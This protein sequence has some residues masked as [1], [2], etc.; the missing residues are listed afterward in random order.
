MNIIHIAGTK[1]KGSTCAFV[2]SL[3]QSHQ[4]RTGFPKKIG[5]YTSPHLIEY[6][7]RIRINSV[8]LPEET[9]GK[10]C[11]DIWNCLDSRPQSN[12]PR[13]L[14]FLALLSYHTFLK[15]GV[16]AAIY[17]THHGGEYDVTNIVEK[18][19]VTALTSIGLDHIG[20]LGPSIENIAWHKAGIFKKDVYAFSVP[21]DPQVKQ[22]LRNRAVE[23]DVA[24]RFVD[25]RQDLPGISVSTQ[26]INASL[27]IEITATFLSSQKPVQSLTHHDIQTGVQNFAWPGRFQIIQ[28][29][30]VRWYLDGSHNPMSA[31][32]AAKWFIS[33]TMCVYSI[34][35]AVYN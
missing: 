30:S 13:Y 24:L 33:D 5:L 11:F 25:V 32:E 8:D 14:Q 18:P 2:E 28:Q 22:V 10:Y 4:N 31:A 23:K 21:Q 34:P 27:A 16:D 12:S 26:R 29:Q 19:I 9:F 3:L 17:E 7:E 20:E 15:E 6:N 1:G 35:A